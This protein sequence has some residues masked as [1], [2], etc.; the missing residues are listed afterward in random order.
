MP[1]RIEGRVRVTPVAL[2]KDFFVLNP[3]GNHRWWPIAPRARVEVDLRRPNLSWRGEGYLDSNA[4]DEPIETGFRHWEWARGA[5]RDKTV[6][7]YEAER[8]DGSRV[9][10]AVTFDAEGNKQEFTPPQLLPLPRSGWKVDRSAR[11]ESRRQAG[12]HARRYPVL[13]AFDG[14]DDAARRKGD[15]GTRKPLPRPLP[16]AGRAS[17]AAVQDAAAAVV[18]AVT[19][20]MTGLVPA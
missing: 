17:H 12:P 2:T 7:L 9:D 1:G 3:Q 8:R 10:L 13:C 19:I 4:G 16:H 6:I 20:V 14:G 15:A 11:S 18:S 5:M